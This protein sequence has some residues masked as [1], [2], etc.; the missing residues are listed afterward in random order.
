MRPQLAEPIESR[1]FTDADVDTQQ[2]YARYRAEHG[3]DASRFKLPNQHH[4]RSTCQRCRCELAE[5]G[6]VYC[7]SCNKILFPQ[8]YTPEEL[9]EGDGDDVKVYRRVGVD[10]YVEVFD[11]EERGALRSD[12]NR[13][14]R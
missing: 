12:G 1:T 7:R 13:D 4:R 8:D 10:H 11:H 9:A 3:D 14:D 6:S 2:E 5:K